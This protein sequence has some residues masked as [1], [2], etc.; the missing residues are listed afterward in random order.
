MQ[1]IVH[2]STDSHSPGKIDNFITAYPPPIPSWITERILDFGNQ[3]YLILPS[4]PSRGSHQVWAAVL[5]PASFRFLIGSHILVPLIRQ[6]KDRSFFGHP[7]LR[8]HVTS[9]QG[10]CLDFHQLVI[11]HAGRTPI[12]ASSGAF[13]RFP[14]R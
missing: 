12:G 13:R 1:H 5:T 11:D 10:S 14:R 7:C 4:R 8:L 6:T 9:F 2:L 3:G